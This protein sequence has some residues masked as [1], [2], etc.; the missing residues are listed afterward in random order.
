MPETYGRDR[1]GVVIHTTPAPEAPARSRAALWR[2]CWRGEAPA[3]ELPA[4]ERDALVRAL[5]RLGWSVVQV[6]QHTRMSTYTTAR[7]V[8]RV[9]LQDQE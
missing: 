4:G 6:A 1:F 5:V 7:I 2:A 9:T 8:Q 3:E